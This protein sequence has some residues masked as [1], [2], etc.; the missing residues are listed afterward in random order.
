MNKIYQNA[1]E[2]YKSRTPKSKEKYDEAL[3]YMTGGET[4][5]IV[6]FNP[7]PLTI[8]YGVGAYLYDLDHNKYIDFLNNYTSMIH[9]H[10]HPAIM[11][12]VKEVLDKGVCYGAAIPEQI[13]LSRRICERVPGIERVRFCNSG[14]EAVLFAIRAARAYTKKDA[15]IKMEGC[16]HVSCDVVQ[17]SIAPQIPHENPLDP[18]KAY[19]SCLGIPQNVTKDVYV[20]P[21]N[22]SDVVADIL[23][24]KSKNIATI[25]LEPVMGQ[26]G[27]IAANPDYLKK[28]RELADEYNVLLIFDEIQC[29]RIDYHGIQGKY[30]VLPD[31]TT[32]G[33]WIGGGYPIAA[34][35]G[36]AAIMDVYNPNKNPHIAQ[37]GT[38]N[39]NKLGMA[40][41]IVSMD[42]YDKIAVKRINSLGKKLSD[43]MQ[44]SIDR[45]GLPITVAQQGSLIHVHFTKKLPIDYAST[46][47]QYNSCA[48]ILH[49]LL[50]NEGIFIAPR[51]SMN[52]STVMTEEDIATAIQAFDNVM[53]KYPHFLQHSKAKNYSAIV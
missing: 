26:T 51:G 21:F 39:G 31:L 52:I 20:A 49:M 1:I 18:W 23:K 6:F 44:K 37:S 25:I 8:D 22:N 45:R 40:A 47:S 41:G 38:F 24:A 14:T 15:I 3:K 29:F 43:G 53:E 46:K 13:G 19:P 48:P 33:K 9:G 50:L 42:L 30:N 35:G 4:R 11:G 34:F 32:L 5:S 36:K 12:A 28:L 17:H 27:A 2:T 16:F 10:A 7:Y